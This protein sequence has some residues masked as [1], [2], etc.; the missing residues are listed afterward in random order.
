[1][2]YSMTPIE[3]A[4]IEAQ[5]CIK[6]GVELAVAEIAKGVEGGVGLAVANAAMLAESLHD[7]KTVIVESA[8]GSV[9]TPTPVPM[10]TEADIAKVFPSAVTQPSTGTRVSQYIS[11]EDYAMVHKLY[12]TEK[13]SGVAYGSKDSAFMCNQAIRKLFNNGTR[14]FPTDYW[15]EGYRGKEI[16]MTKNGKC[17][18]GDFKLKK[19]L[20][21]D[22][23]GTPV[24][25][26]GEGS[27]PLANKSGYFG[28]LVKHTPFSWADRPDPLDPQGWLVGI[29]A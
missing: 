1:M 7:L 10:T 14:V 4:S 24:L 6:A 16:P 25:G 27:H 19:G 18:L 23:E 9:Q 29:D 15:A 26:S 20:S 5:V 8:G 11:D 2:A 12:M 28:A 3:R 17:G 21:L 13:A 22:A